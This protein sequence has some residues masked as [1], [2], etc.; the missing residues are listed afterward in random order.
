[1]EW[2]RINTAPKTDYEEIL[3]AIPRYEE[4]EYTI[5]IAMWDPENDGWTVFL[6][7]WGAEPMWWM[8]MP[9]VP[10]FEPLLEQSDDRTNA[11]TGSPV[12]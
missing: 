5:R 3:V 10:E 11:S 1:M 7:N 8:P 4:D 2:Q 9:K 12:A 6:C